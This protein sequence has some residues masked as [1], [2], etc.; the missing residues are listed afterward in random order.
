M[1]LSQLHTYIRIT[2]TNFCEL[3]YNRSDGSVYRMKRGR[4]KEEIMEEG[5]LNNVQRDTVAP[6]SLRAYFLQSATNL[7]IVVQYCGAK[8]EE[9]EERKRAAEALHR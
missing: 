1:Q 8:K 3:A 5:R 6:L 7:R 9:D 4:K 2:V